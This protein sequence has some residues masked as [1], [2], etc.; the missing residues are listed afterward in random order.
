MIRYGI[1][2]SSF[3]LSYL[4]QKRDLYNFNFIFN[5][6]PEECILFEYP[7]FQLHNQA[8]CSLFWMHGLSFL[9]SSSLRKH[10]QNR[11]TTD[12]SLSGQSTEA[13][14]HSADRKHRTQIEIVKVFPPLVSS[15]QVKLSQVT[16]AGDK[17]CLL[18]PQSSKETDFQ[19]CAVS[20]QSS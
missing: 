2:F 11:K 15:S 20:L 9:G 4:T 16:D 12:S 1:T 18:L 13:L 14:V 10:E 17:L 3:L 19:P 6:Q 8:I 7:P 5:Y